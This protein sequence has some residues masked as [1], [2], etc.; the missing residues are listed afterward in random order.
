MHRR[1]LRVARST[2]PGNAKT[3]SCGASYDTI[4]HAFCM[5]FFELFTPKKGDRSAKK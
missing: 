2:V 1:G 4:L 5:S 3:S